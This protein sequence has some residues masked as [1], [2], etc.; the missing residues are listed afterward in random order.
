MEGISW[1]DE[2]EEREERGEGKPNEVVTREGIEQYTSRVR[3]GRSKGHSERDAEG[4]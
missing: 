2:R 1:R 4:H 3:R